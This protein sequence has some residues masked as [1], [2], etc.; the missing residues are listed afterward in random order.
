[1][2]ESSLAFESNDFSIFDEEQFKASISVPQVQNNRENPSSSELE[3]SS[4][5]I[6][7]SRKSPNGMTATE[8]SFISL[9]SEPL[10]NSLS[11]DESSL[12][13]KTSS[14][15]NSL[16]SS[17]YQPQSTEQNKSVSSSVSSE[18]ISIVQSESLSF[19]ASRDI[20]NNHENVS[21]DHESKIQTEIDKESKPSTESPNQVPKGK[22]K[23][24]LN[25]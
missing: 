20:Q 10:L 22:L 5:R 8:L 19:S 13:S 7:R 24:F 17:S 15:F 21:N 6:L 3:S 2:W 1:M 25:N 16:D 14:D 18:F 23:T 4:E 11:S 12:I 9:S